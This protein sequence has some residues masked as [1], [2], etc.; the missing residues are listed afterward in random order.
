MTRSRIALSVAISAC[1]ASL[2]G[3]AVFVGRVFEDT[4]APVALDAARAAADADAAES[5][6]AQG[7][8]GGLP[9][10]ALAGSALLPGGLE[11]AVTRAG[12]PQPAA[13]V[14][15]YVRAGAAAGGASPGWR[16]A[17]SA[18]ASAEGLAVLPVSPRAFLLAVRAPGVAP[19]HVQV[20]RPVGQGTLRLTVALVEGAVLSGRV[21]AR[22]TGEAVPLATVTLLPADEGGGAP[23]LLPDEERAF[24]TS[25]TSGR[26]RFAVSPGPYVVEA[27]ATGFTR[28]RVSAAAPLAGL[29]VRL[30]GGAAVEGF[31]RGP[32]GAPAVGAEVLVAGGEEL[33]RGTV[34]ASGGF[35]V[36]VTPGTYS[37]S[38]RNERGAGAW[39]VPVTVAAGGTAR[40]IEIR[41][42]NPGAI[43]GVVAGADGVGVPGASIVITPNEAGGEFARAE[44]DASGVFAVE[45]LAAGSYDL[46][47]T[48]DGWGPASRA[49]LS[50]LPGQK[51]ELALTL[52]RSGGVEGTVKDD[53]GRPLAGI[54]VRATR[55][56][57]PGAPRAEART[58]AAGYFRLE[59]LDAGPTEIAALRDGASSGASVSVDV[60]Q[61]AWATV[62]LALPASGRLEG[63]VTRRDRG[64]LNQA[65]VVVLQRGSPQVIAS[66][67]VDPGGRYGLELAAGDYRVFAAPAESDT[68]PGRQ[69]PAPVSIAAGRVQ[70]L[71]LVM[72]TPEGGSGHPSAGVVHVVEPNG[73]G[74]AGTLVMI[75]TADDLHNAGSG[76]TDED[77]MA[78]IDLSEGGNLLARAF[79]GG[80]VGGPVPLATSGTTVVK[81]RAASQL[82]GHVVASDGTPAIGFTLEVM[83][84]AEDAWVASGT[85]GSAGMKGARGVEAPR[86]LEFGGDRFELADVPGGPV[87]VSVRTPGG[88]TGH[89]D[90]DLAPGQTREVEVVLDPGTTIEGRVVDGRSRSPLKG[91]SVIVLG[92]PSAPPRAEATTGA[93]GTFRVAGVPAGVRRLRFV[94]AGFAPVER[95]F[96]ADAG[97]EGASINLG[98]VALVGGGDAA[99]ATR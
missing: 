43:V 30:A 8:Q 73:T 64:A 78:H 34:G 21:L 82:R 48:A 63:L 53:G 70:T 57:G 95:D 51:M 96:E 10:R 89:I 74:S 75:T 4:G 2:A 7:P 56:T 71:D 13:E 28:A 36:E 20:L 39:P 23:L 67:K 18:T 41:L 16:L 1:V 91:A 42:G 45:A 37:V 29:D 92:D 69:P 81:L 35:S 24:A 88:R 84:L 98:D 77:G 90:F 58:D 80:R 55:Q 61:G 27:S 50:I 14:K 87:R 47:V 59:G 6:Y 12:A 86:K 22:A 5:P 85:G 33:A 72:R 31:V 54:R 93:S 46:A 32:D 79:R 68:A 3:A 44:T 25:D 49:G 99:T 15:V 83:S 26:F 40:G 11:V 94:A 97:G 38:A 65:V 60:P 52:V 19:R 17:G 9:E 62:E 76:L 66:A